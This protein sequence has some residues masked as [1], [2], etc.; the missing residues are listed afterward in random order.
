MSL[1]EWL[2]LLA[3]YVFT[4]LFYPGIIALFWWNWVQTSFEVYN[5]GNISDT[6]WLSFRFKEE[7]VGKRSRFSMKTVI[8]RLLH[9]SW[10]SLLGLQRFPVSSLSWNILIRFPSKL[11]AFHNIFLVWMSDAQII[12]SSVTTETIVTM[13]LIANVINNKRQLLTQ[14]Q[15]IG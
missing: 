14:Y 13:I 7:K 11:H 8:F 4:F 12:F 10:M 15:C 6:L 3:I 5:C 2:C 1:D 9:Y